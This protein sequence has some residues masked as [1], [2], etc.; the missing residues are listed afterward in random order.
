MAQNVY[1]SLHNSLVNIKKSIPSVVRCL[2]QFAVADPGF[3]DVNNEID[4]IALRGL[5]AR[6]GSD[7][8]GL[9]QDFEGKMAGLLNSYFPSDNLRVDVTAEVIN[10]LNDYR[11]IVTIAYP[12]GIPVFEIKDIVISNG[13]LVNY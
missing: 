12:N 4:G 8:E 13:K 1:I 10:D 5:M 3:T 2:L 7:M 9:A 11:L 6:H